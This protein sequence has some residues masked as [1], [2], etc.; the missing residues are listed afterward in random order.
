MPGVGRIGVLVSV[1]DDCKAV[2]S[3]TKS[4]VT[5]AKAPSTG[6][7][8][9]SRLFIIKSRKKKMGTDGGGHITL[10]SVLRNGCRYRCRGVCERQNCE[11]R[12]PR[13][14]LSFWHQPYK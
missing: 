10:M 5:D 11:K 6:F 4:Q 3:A 14:M 2:L 9:N 13:S 12:I 7:G 8:K 1:L